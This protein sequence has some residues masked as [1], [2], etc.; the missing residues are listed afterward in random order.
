[1]L[2]LVGAL[3]RIRPAVVLTAMRWPSLAAI[4]A[5]EMFFR[6]TPVVLWAQGHVSRALEG[7]RL[8]AYRAL[9]PTLVR[10][11]YPRAQGFIAVSHGVKEDLVRQFGVPA[12]RIRVIPNAVELKRVRALAAEEPGLAVDWRV[13]TVIAVGRLTAQKGFR[14]LLDAFA[15]LTR[16]RSCQLLIVGEGRDRASLWRQARALGIHEWVHMVGFQANPF[17]L[18]A[19]SRVFVLSSLWEGFPFVLLEAMACGVPVVSTDCPSGPGELIV[20]GENGLLVPPADPVALADAMEALLVDQSRA[21][22]LAEAA[23]IRLATFR[24]EALVR[25]CEEVLDSLTRFT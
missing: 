8:R 11:L 22:R 24:P 7:H 6:R 15:R 16:Q 4:A 2:R 17:A 3:R 18:M 25:Q 9:M 20:N 21:A 23:S 19:R 14:H 13:S 1:M 10:R 12:D 5:C